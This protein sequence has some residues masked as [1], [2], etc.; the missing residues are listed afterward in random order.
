M[1]GNI[2]VASKGTA[3]PYAFNWD[4]VFGKTTGREG[5]DVKPRPAR[6]TSTPKPAETTNSET[7]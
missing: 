5:A 7:R 2:R 4:A 1:S 6:E 3:D